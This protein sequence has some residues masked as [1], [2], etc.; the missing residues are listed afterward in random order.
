MF[1]TISEVGNKEHVSHS[2]VSNSLRPHGHSPRGSSVHGIFP[3]RI[4]EWIAMPSSREFSQKPGIKPTSPA[5]PAFQADSL[6]LSHHFYIMYYSRWHSSSQQS[7][8]RWLGGCKPTQGGILMPLLLGSMFLWG[9][10]GDPGCSTHS[11]EYNVLVPTFYG[12]VCKF[13]CL[14]PLKKLSI[15]QNSVA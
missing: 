13:S 3:A 10:L 8:S 2:V 12:H 6:L 15:F 9:T 1:S 4:L 14:L 7:S 11:V 5:S